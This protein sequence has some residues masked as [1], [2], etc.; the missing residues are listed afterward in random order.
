MIPPRLAPVVFGLILSGLMS[1]L[2][3][4]V[5]TYRALGMIEGFFGVWMG[6]WS[7]SWA[8]AFP[9]VLIVAPI[10]RRIVARFTASA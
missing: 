9:T 8:V 5:S 4:G 1:F 7:F 10:A 6:N 2:V 3:S